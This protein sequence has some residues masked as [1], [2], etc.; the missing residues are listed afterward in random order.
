[1]T[2]E[3][4][5]NLDLTAILDCVQVQNEPGSAIGR[6]FQTS[7]NCLDKVSTIFKPS[8]LV[9]FTEKP[10]LKPIPLSS[11]TS[12]TRSVCS[13]K[14]TNTSPL[15]LSG[16]A[17]LNAF[18]S[19]S[20]RI[21]PHGIARSISKRIGLSAK[22]GDQIPASDRGR[23]NLTLHWPSSGRIRRNRCPSDWWMHRASREFWPWI[24][25]AADFR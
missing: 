6:D 21:R 12:W 10:S 7:P 9:S 13:C 16:N 15:R 14:E 18:E 19:N 4:V 23:S 8:D 20:F 24:A 1:M 25:H 17:Y 2:H 3:I 22:N 5:R 11:T